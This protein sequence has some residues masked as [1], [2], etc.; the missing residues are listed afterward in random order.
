MPFRPQTISNEDVQRARRRE[1]LTRL[2]R[3][4][5]ISVGIMGV[6]V[7]LGWLFN[8]E[9]LKRPL[10]KLVAMNPLTATCFI[11]SSLSLFLLTRS[12]STKRQINA[13]MSIAYVVIVISM[14]RLLSLTLSLN[15]HID[16]WLFHNKLEKDIAGN[17][18]NRMA[19]NTAVAFL[20]T[21]VALLM[22]DR[23]TTRGR[24]PSQYIALAIGTLGMLSVLGYMYQVGAFYGVLAYIPMAIHTAIC[25][26]LIAIAIMFAHPEKGL[27][28]VFT[29]T[30][31]GA[32]NARIMIPAAII[33]PQV[34]G[35]FRLYSAWAGIF[36]LEFGTAVLILCTIMIFLIVVWLTIRELNRKD[37][38]RLAALE[39]LRATNK[40]L[41]AFSYSVSHDLRAPLR[42]IQGYTQMLNEDY[43]TLLDDEG[44]RII[45]VVKSNTTRMGKLI[46]SLLAFSHLGRKEIQKTNIDMNGLTR[47]VFD[48]IERSARHN[49]NITIAD[50]HN[51]KGD[52][53]LVHQVMLNL[54][55]N[56]LK[57]SS[58]KEQPVIEISSEK[59]DNQV[60]FSV[61][62][63]G[64]GFDMQFANKLFGVF[65][66]L[67]TDNEFEGTGI[68]LAIINRIVAKHGGQVWAEGKV[69]EGAAFYFTLPED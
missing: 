34:L 24:V 30:E 61:K 49:A 43:G 62:D 8:I 4:L 68:G 28:A 16:E 18:S 1:V 57:Y 39:Q 9:L 19:P 41:E 11:L 67:H 37:A 53:N 36:S 14:T 59:K 21:G 25:F 33:I 44:K 51:A 60:I 40:E 20:F 12:A 63:N 64:A 55:S 5:T 69:D 6:L 50:L 15:I 31:A 22:L 7:L 66:R 58:K 2:S 47:N 46:D 3:F 32:T 48:E 56:A 10:P 13:A 54:V 52:Y 26:L 45:D 23:Q 65:Q 17:V 42:A 35:L 38:L 29:S 27:M